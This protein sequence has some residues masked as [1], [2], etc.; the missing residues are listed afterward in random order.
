MPEGG[1]PQES[2]ESSEGLPEGTPNSMP[3]G[4]EGASQDLDDLAQ[5]AE[6]E[7]DVAETGTE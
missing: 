1:T 2:G 7:E 6:S 4:A 3:N 5:R